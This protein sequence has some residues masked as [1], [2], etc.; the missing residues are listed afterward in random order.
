ML[1]HQG[2]DQWPLG[3][4]NIFYMRQYASQKYQFTILVS[5]DLTCAHLLGEDEIIFE[6]C[7]T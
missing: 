1:Y 6:N 3:I 7:L 2:N 5:Y 4:F